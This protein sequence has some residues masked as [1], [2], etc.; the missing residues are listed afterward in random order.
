MTTRAVKTDLVNRNFKTEGSKAPEWDAF[1]L[2]DAGIFPQP[3]SS[4]KFGAICN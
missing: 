1:A 2:I 3:L 4:R